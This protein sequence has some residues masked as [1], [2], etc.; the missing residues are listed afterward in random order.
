[1]KPDTTD[2]SHL[3]HPRSVAVAGA[4]PNFPKWGSII[5]HN[6][7][8]GGYTGKVYPVNPSARDIF[9]INAYPSLRAI[10]GEVDLVFVVVPPRKVEDVLIDAAEKGV[11]MAVIITAGFSETGDDGKS[12]EEAIVTRA[13]ALGIRLIGPNCMGVASL[14]PM[15]LT[16]W[17][18]SFIPTDGSVSIV[19][20]SGNVGYS[21]ARALSGRGIGV[22]RSISS[23]NEADLTTSDFIRA[24]GDDEHTRVILSYVEG[25]DEGRDFISALSETTPKKPVV[26]LKAGHTDAGARAG[27]SHTGAMAG[28][29][30]L[31]GAALVQTGALRAASL[32]QLIDYTSVLINQPLPR[33]RRVGILTLGGGWG[34][35]A[36]D[37]L[38]VEGLFVTPLTPATIATLD[39]VLPSWWSR[40]NPVDTV[41]G[42]REGDLKK[43][44]EV[45]LSA[46]YIDSLVLCG[47]GYGSSRGSFFANSPYADMYGMK[48]L[49][50]KFITEDEETAEGIVE[51][52]D[53]YG[54]P[55]IPVVDQGIIEERGTFVEILKD[56]GVLLFPSPRRAAASLAA[57]TRYAEHLGRHTDMD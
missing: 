19:S 30:E 50:E 42:L 21:L 57:L 31:Y 11:R 49:G 43:C 10:P 14:I 20:Q 15:K 16:A 48:N 47:F 23:G 38:A 39:T 53:A 5:L 33:G 41:A 54:K 6:I 52:I 35:L 13:R 45:L 7:L 25:I 18:P 8:R 40:G 32:D 27:N 34:V 55:I 28:A 12:I 37:A 24:L 26:V 29:D 51:M 22:C 36:A 44:L 56:R 9:G 3:F 17:M 2:F 4:S 1:M 46:D